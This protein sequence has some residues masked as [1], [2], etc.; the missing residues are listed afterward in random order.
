MLKYKAKW[1]MD[2]RYSK[3]TEILK[4]QK[5]QIC[6]HPIVFCGDGNVLYLH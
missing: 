5:H 2:K 3:N 4:V 6:D 1:S